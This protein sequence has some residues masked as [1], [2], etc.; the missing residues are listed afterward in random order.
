MLIPKKYHIHVIALLAVAV[1]IFYPSFSNRVDPQIRAAGTEAAEEFLQLIDGEQ[2]E[3]GWE[4]SSQLMRDK[5]FLEVWNRQIPAMRGKVG[6]LNQRQQESAALSD[7]AEG[8]PDGQY[9][10]LKYTSSFEKQ[11]AAVE[12]VILVL[13]ED[14]RWRVAGYFIK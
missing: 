6:A 4:N 5:I 12:T 11:A 1:M 9:L 7:W 13:E 14:A 3:L 8:A 10:T 2:Y